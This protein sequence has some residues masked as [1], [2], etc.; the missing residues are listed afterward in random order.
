MQDADAPRS[1]RA[2]RVLNSS[3]RGLLLGI[4]AVI[5]PAGLVL[6]NV[7]A[8]VMGH[9]AAF[10]V[11]ITASAVVSTILLNGLTGITAYRIG[12]ANWPDAWLFARYRRRSIAALFAFAL[13]LGAALAG[14]L[15]YRGLSDPRLL[16]NLSTFVAGLIG[17]AIPIV[18]AF[19]LRQDASRRQRR[20]RRHYRTR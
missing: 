9:L 19:L 15:T 2:Q 5:T 13:G 10:R 17:L 3:T 8:Y 14:E 7:A 20:Q 18:L 16:P 1:G 11:A 12:Q 4:L 6:V